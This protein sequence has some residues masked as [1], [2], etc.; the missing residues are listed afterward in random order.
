MSPQSPCSRH[1]AQQSC[2]QDLQCGSQTYSL[3]HDGLYTHPKAAASPPSQVCPRG[4]VP[5]C[6]ASC[7]L[8]YLPSSLRTN[9]ELPH[10]QSGPPD[11]IPASFLHKLRLPLPQNSGPSARPRG[12]TEQDSLLT[13]RLPSRRLIFLL[14]E[15]DILVTPSGLD[16]I[17]YVKCSLDTRFVSQGFPS[18]WSLSRLCLAKKIGPQ[19]PQS[20]KG[21]SCKFVCSLMLCTA[22]CRASLGN[23]ASF[24]ALSIC[25]KGAGLYCPH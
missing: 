20:S 25:A 7:S 8:S 9:G 15:M 1:P 17:T 16:A 24:P 19:P 4:P 2:P 10:P 3:H 12:R 13:C 5:P 23:R 6:P 11:L 14:C 18:A 21:A 22:R